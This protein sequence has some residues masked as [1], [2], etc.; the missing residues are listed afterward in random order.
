[1][2]QWDQKP[3]SPIVLWKRLNTEVPQCTRIQKD[4]KG[5]RSPFQSSVDYETR[6]CQSFRSVQAGRY[7]EE[8]KEAQSV[9]WVNGEGHRCI[10]GCRRSLPTQHLLNLRF[11]EDSET[12]SIKLQAKTRLAVQDTR[13]LVSEKERR[14]KCSW[15]TQEGTAAASRKSSQRQV[16]HGSWLYVN[17]LQVLG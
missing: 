12:E 3:K 14:N 16:Q 10:D 15:M 5:S 1:M 4:V 8:E 13:H 7:T 9:T 11:L 17:L 6:K 2:N